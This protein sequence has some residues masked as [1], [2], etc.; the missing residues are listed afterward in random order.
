MERKESLKITQSKLQ[1]DCNIPYE[2]LIEI[3]SQQ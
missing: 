3:N 2:Q 1:S